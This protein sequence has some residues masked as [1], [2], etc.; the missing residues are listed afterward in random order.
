MRRSLTH[1]R[2][3]RDREKERDR[4]YYI[5]RFL[6]SDYLFKPFREL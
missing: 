5:L 4:D 3:D 2:G 6:S 1:G